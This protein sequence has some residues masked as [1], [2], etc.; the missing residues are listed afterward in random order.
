MK[1][2]KKR[3]RKIKNEYKIKITKQMIMMKM[4]EINYQTK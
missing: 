4:N 1:K 3:K 2:S